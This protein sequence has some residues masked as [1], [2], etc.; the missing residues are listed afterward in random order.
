M[1]RWAVQRGTS[2]VTKSVTPAR[3]EA[4]FDVWDWELDAEDFKVID[5]IN[6]GWRSL[7]T[8]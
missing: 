2:V 6:C 3:V 8:P 5:S 4:N 1:L 7:H